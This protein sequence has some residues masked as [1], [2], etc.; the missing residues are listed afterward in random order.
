MQQKRKITKEEKE[1]LL[2]IKPEDID[3]K[4]L[5]S[6]F[7]DTY[8]YDGVGKKGKIVHS[9]FNT[10]DEFS[11]KKGE[12]TNKEDVPVTNCGLFIVNKFLFE[13]DF[14]DIIGYMNTPLNKKQ[15]EN[16]NG[17][18]DHALLEDLISTTTYITYLN[19]LAWLAFSFHTDVSSSL[20][21]KSMKELPSVK[22]EKERLFKQNKEKLDAGDVVVATNIEK[23]LIAVARDEMKYDPAYELYDSGARGG[24]NNSYKNAQIMKGPV[25]NSAKGRFEIMRNPLARGIDKGDI[26]VLANSVIDGA[27]SK[28]NA[29]GECGH[30]TK[31][32]NAGFQSAILGKKDSDC[33]TKGY[34]TVLLTD[35]NFKYYNYKYIIEGSKLVRLS[36]DNKNKY[37]GKVVKMRSN[38]YC[39]SS[40]DI[41]NKCAGDLYF[42]LNIMTIGLTASKISNALLNRRMKVFHDS[43]VSTTEIH[44][45]IDII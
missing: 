44:P 27:F 11:L 10:F 19:R 9:R 15:L 26:P 20:S 21:I 31:K 33:G 3:L 28:S 41:C 18:L 6:L 1:Y 17:I 2:S 23:Q 40:R 7:S 5:Q 30:L 8:K 43:T 4:L 36:T 42:M 32:I 29:T 34:S 24:F 13:R 14:V 12:Y 22:K 25:Y 35:K 45:D 16:I 39:T 37:I 38:M